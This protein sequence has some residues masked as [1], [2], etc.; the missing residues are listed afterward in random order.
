MNY[1]EVPYNKH[2]SRDYATRWIKW[3]E[4]ES[5]VWDIQIRTLTCGRN[6]DQIVV[7][8]IFTYRHDVHMKV[9]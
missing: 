9:I 6:G 7:K 4:D 1:F 3:L 2:L 5:A 8:S